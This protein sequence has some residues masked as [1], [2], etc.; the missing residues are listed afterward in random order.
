MTRIAI[1]GAGTIGAVHAT[2]YRAAGAE[3]VAIVEPVPEAAE[4]FARRFDLAAY[5]SLDDLLASPDRPDAISICTP[6]FTHR[7]LATAALD[8]GLH[9]LCEKPMAHTLDDAEAIFRA[10]EEAGSTFATAYCHRFQPEIEAIA[11]LIGEGRIGAVRSFYNAFTGNQPGIETRWFGRKRLAGGGAVMDTA[12][13]SIDIFRYLCGEVVD[14]TGVAT[15]TL[16]GTELEVEHTA[17]LGLVSESGVI[18]TID[19][20][21]K[22]APGRAVVQVTGA[23]GRLSFDYTQPGHVVFEDEDGNAERIPAGGDDRF[24]R[25]IRSFLQAVENGDAPRT[26]A[27]D[28]LVG[29]AVVDAVYRERSER[30]VRLPSVAGAVLQRPAV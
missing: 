9:V 13:H 10:A 1:V 14:G 26:G 11:G 21:W 24:L 3:L 2:A 28:G 22:S 7:E 8:A 12:I 30:S 18:G 6:P 27:I 29:L 23:M 4:S 20:S 15:D 5:G 19:C 25:E 16:D 17:T